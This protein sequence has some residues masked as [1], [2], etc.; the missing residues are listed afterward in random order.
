MEQRENQT[1][2]ETDRKPLTIVIHS[3]G[4]RAIEKARESVRD[5]ER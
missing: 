3:M 2:T 1:K 4:E 5:I